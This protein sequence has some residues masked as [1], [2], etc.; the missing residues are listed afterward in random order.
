MTAK[1]ASLRKLG[2]CENHVF[3]KTWVQRCSLLTK[4]STI[5][6]KLL[7]SGNIYG[8]LASPHKCWIR[9]NPLGRKNFLTAKC[10]SLRK[11]RICENHVFCKTWVQRCSLLTKNSTI[12]IKLL[13]SGNIYGTL[14]SP[15]KCWIRNSPL[16]RKNSFDRKM[17]LFKKT[18]NL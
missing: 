10:A 12:H 15:Y 13:P 17:C 18:E 3:C 2:I 5:H 4:N 14:A 8:T 9:Y 6:I 16:G 7:P 1:C 11:L